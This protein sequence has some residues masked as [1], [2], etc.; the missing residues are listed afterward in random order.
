MPKMNETPRMIDFDERNIQGSP[1]YG[2]NKN[3][4]MD[5]QVYMNNAQYGQLEDGSPVILD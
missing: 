5:P 4:Y 2:M 1:L 3:Y